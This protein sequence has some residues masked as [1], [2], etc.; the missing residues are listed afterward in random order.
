MQSKISDEVVAAQR[1]I[2]DK[3][4]ACERRVSDV[5]AAFAKSF[6]GTCDFWLALS[7]EEQDHA[8]IL[9]SMKRFLDA[10]HYFAK[11]GLLTKGVDAMMRDLDLDI[12]MAK[13]G[14]LSEPEAF[15]HAVDH[16]SRLIDGHFYDIV[17]CGAPEF[18]HM[19]SV[20]RKSCEFHRARIRDRM[21]ERKSELGASWIG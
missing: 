20:L 5:Y 2:V 9:Q 17:E 1:A 18:H 3:L 10:G 12:T 4:A 21:L 7:K 8:A 14:T 16:E 11:I 15:K 19:A 13:G 6:P